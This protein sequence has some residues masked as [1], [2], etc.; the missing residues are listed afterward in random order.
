MAEGKRSRGKPL[1]SRKINA[2]RVAVKIRWTEAEVE[3]V[4]AAA[5]LAGEDFS[6]F[7]RSSALARSRKI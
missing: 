7:V 3:L 5:D 2:R 4:R 6:N 1:G